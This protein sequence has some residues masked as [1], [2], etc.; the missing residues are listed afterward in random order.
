MKVVS[1]RL[2]EATAA[3]YQLMADQVWPSSIPLST[4]LKQRLEEGDAIAEQLASLRLDVADLAAA[5]KQ[6]DGLPGGQ[7]DAVAIETLLLL[8]AVANP[9]AVRIVHGELQRLG[10]NPWQAITRAG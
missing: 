5:T 1:I 3:R 2:S 10:I 9:R 8:R 7:P 4:Y 6:R